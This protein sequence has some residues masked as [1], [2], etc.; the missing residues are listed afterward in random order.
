MIAD[1]SD[2]GVPAALFMVIVKTLI[3]NQA[4][5]GQSAQEILRNVN[6][7]LCENN[8]EKMFATVWLGILDI[9]SGKMVCAN[10]GHE[11]PIIKDGK[12]DF[13][14]YKDRHGLVLAGMKGFPYKEYELQLK[15]EDILLFIQMVSAKR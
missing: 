10:A 4:K 7:Q 9:P 15:P 2:K 5:T 8:K 13:T 14:L 3:K 12:G 1:V 11:Y 6:D